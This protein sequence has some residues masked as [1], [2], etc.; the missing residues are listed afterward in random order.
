MGFVAE[1]AV[2]FGVRVALAARG[3]VAVRHWRLVVVLH[4]HVALVVVVRLMV[5]VIHIVRLVGIGIV[6]YS[7]EKRKKE[8]AKRISKTDEAA[9]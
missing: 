8:K 4:H 1:D 7:P 9:S 6:E 3:V 5:V 2:E